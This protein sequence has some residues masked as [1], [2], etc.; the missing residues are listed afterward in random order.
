MQMI[1]FLLGILIVLTFL[2]RTIAVILSKRW[3]KDNLNNISLYDKNQW[4]ELI[5]LIPGLREQSLV[6]ETIE[7]F[8]KMEYIDGKLSVVFI[9]TDKEKRH[10]E[11]K[12]KF[13]I[14]FDANEATP[15]LKQIT[16]TNNGVFPKYVL[17]KVYN[18]LN[19]SEKIEDMRI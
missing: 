15:S 11:E 7:H 16:Y 12:T 6:S 8:E 13:K 2:Y 3:I 18:I 10:K 4:P 14:L 1:I 19:Q 5:L 17:T 9:T